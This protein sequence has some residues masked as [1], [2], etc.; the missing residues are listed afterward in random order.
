MKLAQIDY[1]IVQLELRGLHQSAKANLTAYSK[2]SEH[3]ASVWLGMLSWRYTTEMKGQIRCTAKP[4]MKVSC[5]NQYAEQSLDS[6]AMGMVA[7]LPKP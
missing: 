5:E 7:V 3:Q 1:D 6:P 4:E 2:M